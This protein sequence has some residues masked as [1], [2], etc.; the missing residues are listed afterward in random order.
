MLKDFR[1]V[2]LIV[3]DGLGVGELPDAAIYGDTG[4]YTLK[5][6]A[7]AVENLHLPHLESL[8]LGYLD[9]FQ[10]IKRVSQ[11]EGAYGIM[12]EVSAGKDSITGHWELM[13]LILKDPFPTFP[14]G[15]PEEVIRTFREA[16]G[17]EILGNY[18][19]SGTEIIKRLGE[20]HMVTGYPIVYTSADSVFQ[21]AAHEDIIP[22]EKLYKICEIAR[23]LLTGA[24]GVSRVIARP[25]I[26]K[27]GNFRRTSR[28]KDFSLPP[29]E[30][31]LL[32]ALQDTGIPTIGIGK[33]GDIFADQGIGEVIYTANNE[34]GVDKTIEAI[35]R[36][37]CGFFFINLID[38]DMLYGHR[39]DV[40]GYANALKAFDRKLPEIINAMS[41][42]D[43]LIITSDHGCDP[44]T[45]STDHSREYVPLLIYGTQIKRGTN[46]G[47]RQT[48]ADLGQTIAE[49]FRLKPLNNGT[50]FAKLL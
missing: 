10:G 11:P 48:F 27:P 45:E 42:R 30:P 7:E 5:H 49:I 3:L 28:R 6:I 9:N 44:T 4:S 24:N 15:F 20:V 32:D 25:F 36:I 41:E 34:E 47:V 14:N 26:G 1:C 46:L 38:F 37:K 13:G 50:S 19:A 43:L 8:G 18:P 12:A 17:T 23:R 39:N 31:T 40:N 16:I 35:H 22:I 21:I 2:I 29:P 33:I